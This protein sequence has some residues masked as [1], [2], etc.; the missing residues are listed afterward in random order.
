MDFQSLLSLFFFI[1]RKADEAKN[2]LQDIVN[3]LKDP[4]K[5]TV[6]GGKLPKG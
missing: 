2:E 5:Y 6:L 1:F 4:S 3:Y